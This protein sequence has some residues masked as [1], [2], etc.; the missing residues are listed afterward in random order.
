MKSGSDLGI[1]FRRAPDPDAAPAP[2]PTPTVTSVNETSAHLVWSPPSR[3]GAS[4]V[5]SYTVEYYSSSGGSWQI[6]ASDLTVTEFTL[7]PI[8]PESSYGVVVR[9]RNSNGL[10]EPSGIAEIGGQGSWVWQRTREAE[11]IQQIALILEEASP[12]STTTGPATATI[13]WKV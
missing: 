9:A 12:A 5:L 7:S 4:P 11:K 13:L 2:P 1:T 10:S 6:A 8:K 3:Q